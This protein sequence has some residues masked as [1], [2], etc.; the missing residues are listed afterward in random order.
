M[1]QR[2]QILHQRLAF[3]VEARAPPLQ[4]PHKPLLAVELEA[5]AVRGTGVAE[6]SLAVSTQAQTTGFNLQ[7]INQGEVQILS[8]GGH[9]SND[10]FGRVDGELAHLLEQKHRRV[11]L[12]LTLLSSATTMSL[13]RLLVCGREFRRHGGELKLA[14]LSPWLRRM[15]EL[16][17]FDGKNDFATDLATALKAMPQP[18]EAR[19]S[20]LPKAKP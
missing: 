20:S 3:K 13:A 4:P 5:G 1:G 11:I 16:S 8:L 9:M 12:D 17:G 2:V 19:Q 18:R 15:A 7:R 6:P 10:E 14:G